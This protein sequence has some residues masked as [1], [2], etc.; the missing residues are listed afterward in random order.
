MRAL[1]Y[2]LAV[3]GEAT[4]RALRGRGWS[5]V[6]ADD[7]ATDETRQLAADLDVGLVERPSAA[8]LATLVADIDLV[9]PS[10]GL[11]EDHA[12]MAAAATAGVPTWSEIELAYRWEQ[13][14]PGGGRPLLAVTGTDGKTTT[15]LLAAAMLEASGRKVALAGNNDLPLVSAIDLDVDV[16]VVECSSFRL[17]L[18]EQF[19]GEA[20]TWLNLAPDH[21]DWH[22]SL[23]SYEGA[24]ANVWAHQRPDDVAIGYAADVIVS[25]HLATAPG[26][27]VTFGAAGADYRAVGDELVG[28]DGPIT[29][30]DAMRRSLPHDVTNALAAAA[31]VLEPGLASVDGVGAA[32]ADFE[33]PSHRIQFV[34]EADEIAWFD[35]SKATT[36]HAAATAISGFHHVVLVA[37][38]RNKGL[39]LTPLAAVVDHVRAVV[40]IG[41]AAPEVA[42]VFR[43]RV[44]VEEASSM[45]DAVHAAR[46]LARPGD[47]VLLS[48]ACASFDWYPNYAAR[49]DDFTR[50]VLDELGVRT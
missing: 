18:T 48:P 42:A 38:G 10:P 36:P 26:R 35:D 7:R 8:D 9:S 49:G 30:I 29:S 5:V 13:E 6:V 39:D 46:R 43:G 41:E 4:V 2:G 40:A 23:D 25:R 24:K 50:L 31:T 44:P 21:L 3:T 19:R 33:G 32:L 22:R 34:A 14:R 12:L 16:F 11:P 37:G 1:V 28:P 15:T 45:P 20:A 47:A 27:H 17:A